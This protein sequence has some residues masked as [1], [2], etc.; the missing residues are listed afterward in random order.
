MSIWD[1]IGQ[2]AGEAL[3]NATND[4]KSASENVINYSDEKLAQKFKSETNSAKKMAY[5]LEM[6][7]RSNERNSNS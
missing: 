5:A 1:K 2:K 6:Q 3:K 7:R 4:Y